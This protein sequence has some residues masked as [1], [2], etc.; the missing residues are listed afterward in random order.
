MVITAILCSVFIFSSHFI[1]HTNQTTIVIHI[2]LIQFC[3]YKDRTK[4]LSH[5]VC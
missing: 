5:R 2:R 3:D 4:E 1:Q